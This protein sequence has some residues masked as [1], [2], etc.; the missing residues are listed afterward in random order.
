MSRRLRDMFAGW[1]R[2][3][4]RDICEEF[5]THLA[6]ETERQVEY[7]LPPE[8]ARDL[9]MKRFGNAIRHRE[10]TRAAHGVAWWDHLTHDFRYACRA[11]ARKPVAATAAMIALGIG[12]GGPAAVISLILSTS[13]LV[14]PGALDPD[15]LV[16]LWETPPR[17]PGSRRDPTPETYRVWK[18]QP[19]M[20]QQ[21]S[22]AGSPLVLSLVTGDAPER[23]R[24]QTLDTDLLPLLGMSPELGRAFA[25]R[26]AVANADPVALVSRHFW[27]TRLGHR[28]DVIGST[29]NL[30]G[31]HTTI[32]GVAPRT[33]WFGSRD[34]DIWVPL[35]SHD[36]G[37]AAPV[38]VVA[39][40]QGGD[41]K[42]AVN[43]RLDALSAQV[44]ASQPAREP[45]WGIRVD[46]LGA[47]ELLNSEDLA[48]G[49][50]ILMAAAV[51]GLLAACANIATV[52]VAR[53]AA[54]YLETAVRA[55]L[56]AP[57]TRLVRQFLVESIAVAMG[58]G[59]IAVTLVFAVFRL[60]ASFAPPDLA[61]AIN[62]NPSTSLIAGIAAISLGIGTLAGLGPALTD[63]RVNLLAA[64]KTGGYFGS[65]HGN[66]RLRRAL[67][68]AEVTITVVLLAG[69]TILAKG[70][71]E[72]SS[73]GPGFDESRVITVRIDPVQ[74]I[75]RVA[76]PPLSQDL[77]LERF[78][79]VN[80]VESVAIADGLLGSRTRVTISASGDAAAREQPRTNVN[81][82]TH[83][84]FQT[85]GLR[86]IEGRLLS[87]DD[88]LGAPVTVVSEVFARQNFPDGTAVGHALRIGDET[89]ERTIVGV[90]SNV[91]LD[92]FR[93]QASPMVYVPAASFA[94]PP[95]A[96]ATLELL[97]RFTSGA[98]VIREL[99]RA[100]ATI[101]PLQTITYAA[102]VKD[103]LAAGAA[104]VR[105]T[106]YL[107]GP[108]ILLALALTMSGI[109]G[110]LSQ[111]VTHR[112]HEVAL[113]VALGAERTDVLRLIVVQALRLTVI[114]AATGAAG[115]LVIDRL[116]GSF[117]MGVPGERP[118]ALATATA[119]I[120]IATIIASIVPCQRAVRIDPATTLRYE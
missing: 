92:G 30:H 58:G 106:I 87:S 20:F 44:A 27:E 40:M 103:A 89:T 110:L 62:P 80:G 68:V 1:R 18:A 82:V 38:L 60:I 100:L 104:E 49:F 83:Q 70:A 11:I 33:F 69:V 29:I 50:K 46:G 19:A 55:A 74:H 56:G 61:L 57:R 31:R 7:G 90:V 23:I 43:D 35:P 72:V 119:L 78:A 112:T 84:F 111:T 85:V 67:V 42:Q 21:L 98:S 53:G 120:V 9:A 86:L 66:A 25:K 116:L 10:D 34:V 117:V 45:G 59:L 108:V 88:E 94:R 32:V 75:G 47:R 118:I 15:G 17:Q 5:E 54:R 48:P 107:A 26:D 91:L 65:V 81:G 28:Q 102:V 64:L 16:L 114:G 71:I 115:A 109:Y 8:E 99:H 101:D 96:P 22:A 36:D 113:R 41:H 51:L 63:S 4:D 37:S 6:L 2:D 95:G 3:P 73:I 13:M 79:T 93:R 14:P 97:V 105:F 52:M 77:V 24:V 12:M 76:A 39:R